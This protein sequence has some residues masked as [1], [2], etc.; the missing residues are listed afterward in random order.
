MKIARLLLLGLLA[1]PLGCEN[2]PEPVTP[3]NPPADTPP[4]LESAKPAEP[5]AEE[6]ARKA[7]EEKKKA[8]AE[9][10]KAE[11]AKKLA[12]DWAQLEEDTRAEETRWTP[13]LHAEAKKLA[14]RHATLDSA[15]KAVLKG[16]HR[17]PQSAQRDK[18][19]HPLETL[20]FFGL[21]PSMAVLEY[22]PGEGW[23]TELLAPT[24]AAQGKLFVNIGD[25]KGPADQRGTYYAERLRRFLDRA[26][27]VYGK[28][29]RIQTVTPVPSLG[30]EGKLDM[31]IVCRAMHGMHRNKVLDGFLGE[32]HKALKPGGVLGVEQHR[33]AAGQNPDETAK[34]G[35]LPEAWLIKTIEAAGFELVAKSE[36]NAN[37]KDTRDYPE[38]VWALPPTLE[39]K[40]KD[41]EKLLAVGES[42]RMPLRFAKKRK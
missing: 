35:Y 9:K 40:D 29:E 28:V 15:L 8:E 26:P 20:K 6:V 14:T 11:A 23:Y 37:A 5:S 4:P 38:G 39:R 30:I 12:A 41:R 22:S 10:K 36:V 25:A 32:V 13:A 17:K 31:V 1:A 18:H 21:K 3:Q 27:E 34:N 24:L 2:T 7:E 33:A 42:D 19:R 16:K